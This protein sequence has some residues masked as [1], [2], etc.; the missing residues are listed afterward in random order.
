VPYNEREEAKFAEVPR[1]IG[2]EKAAESAAISAAFGTASAALTHAL[3]VMDTTFANYLTP[4]GSDGACT[5]RINQK[6]MPREA[7]KGC[8]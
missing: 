8:N 3:A 5:P 4:E 7:I 6:S 2:V 1:S